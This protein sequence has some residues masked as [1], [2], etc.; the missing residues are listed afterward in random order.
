MT[1]KTHGLLAARY[2]YVAKLQVLKS[3][4]GYYIGTADENGAPIS[5]ESE[6]YWGNTEDAENALASQAWPQR[7]EA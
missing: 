5:R 3:A 1:I 2:G 4:A 7:L 6:C